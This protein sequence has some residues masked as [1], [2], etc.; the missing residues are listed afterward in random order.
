MSRLRIVALLA[1]SLAV[2][3]CAAARPTPPPPEGG[4]PL[5]PMAFFTGETR[6]TGVLRK[7]FGDPVEIRV[8]G[9]GRMEGDDLILMQTVVMGDKPGRMREWR[10]RRAGPGRFEGTL[11]DAEGPVLIVAEG[12]RATITFRARD[13]YAVRQTLDLVAPG[14]IENRL[15]ARI[16]GL[17]VAELRETIVRP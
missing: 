15:I 17:P 4:P 1:A 13:G 10:L 7:G 5:D 8:A 11:T 6:G 14:R 2:A 12:S 3:A 9:H 16:Y